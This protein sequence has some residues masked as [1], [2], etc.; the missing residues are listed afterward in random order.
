M[1]FHLVSRIAVVD[2][3]ENCSIPRVQSLG[4]DQLPQT[5]PHCSKQ[6]YGRHDIL[7]T[8]LSIATGIKIKVNMMQFLAK[9][10]PSFG[11]AKLARVPVMR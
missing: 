10:F 6:Y 7:N 4:V 2:T 5:P 9:Y 11:T 3:E 8:P 1:K